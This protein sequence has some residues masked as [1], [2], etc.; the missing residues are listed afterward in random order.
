MNI[1]LIPARKGSKRIPNK[2]FKDFLGNP[3]IQYPINVV[4]A[5]SFFDK[6]IIATDNYEIEDTVNT[7]K[8]TVYFRD[9]QNATDESTIMDLVKEVYSIWHFDYCCI[10]YPTAV[11]VNKLGLDISYR[12]IIFNRYISAVSVYAFDNNYIFEY[13]DNELVISNCP[14]KNINND[15]TYKFAGQFIYF[16]MKEIIKTKWNTPIKE[17]IFACNYSELKCQDI[18][19]MED[20]ELAEMKYRRLHG[21]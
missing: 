12:N 15:E 17:P 20:W 14:V 3:I 11:F 19:T 2:N 8:C 5:C 4:R 16:N 6:I 7:N 9:H 13:Q 21:I 18:N 10:V 1:C